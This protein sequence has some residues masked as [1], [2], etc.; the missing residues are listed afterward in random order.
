MEELRKVLG[1]SPGTCPAYPVAGRFTELLR[2]C[3]LQREA[4][5]ALEGAGFTCQQ[6]YD[7]G[8]NIFAPEGRYMIAFGCA[9][10]KGVPRL[11]RD[12]S[13]G[14]PV[15]AGICPFEVAVVDELIE[16]TVKEN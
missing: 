13:F 14:K 5:V 8:T 2:F 16:L 9:N 15:V 7:A 1:A 10:Y 3:P 4:L 12:L 6:L 11:T